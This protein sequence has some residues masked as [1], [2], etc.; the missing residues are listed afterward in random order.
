MTDKD[1]VI[2]LK[3]YRQNKEF[4][5]DLLESLSGL[6]DEEIDDLYDEFAFGNG[7]YDSGASGSELVKEIS[8]LEELEKE[9]SMS[10]KKAWIAEGQPPYLESKVE[11]AILYKQNGLYQKALTHFLEIYQADPNDSLGCRYEIMSLYVLMSNYEMAS[12]FFNSHQ[13]H[14]ED[15][16][17]QVPLLIAAILNGHQETAEELILQL[18]GQVD[19]F[20][21]FCLQDEFPMLRVLDAGA[22]ESY[23]PN[24]E[25]SLYLALYNVLPLLMTASTYVQAWLNNDFAEEDEFLEDFDILTSAQLQSLTNYGIRTVAD[26]ANCSETQLLTIPKIGKATLEKLKEA[27]V[28]FSEK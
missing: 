28:I 27:G 17:M 12:A 3:Q 8:A 10:P 16:L 2:S 24:S 6:T 4:E 21:E 19:G 20:L 11:L 13:E 14:K 25:D 22:L 26:I 9:R 18:C 15:V 7:L 23:Q 1:K 5:A